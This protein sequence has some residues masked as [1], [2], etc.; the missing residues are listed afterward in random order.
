MCEKPF[1]KNYEQAKLAIKYCEKYKVNLVV[2][3]KMRYE[4]I[5][6]ELKKIIDKKTI[7]DLKF[8]SISY[9]Q[10]IP[11]QSWVIKNGI[12]REMFVH[13]LDIVM[14][15]IGSNIKV[16]YID[17]KIYSKYEQR[18]NAK[19]KY[20]KINCFINNG[21]LSDYANLNGKSDFV[22]NAIGSKG[23][24]IL[25]RP[26]FLKVFLSKK[27]ISLNFPKFDYDQPFYN[28][29]KN[30]ISYIDTEKNDQLVVNKECLNFHKIIDKVET[31]E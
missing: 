14:W 3:F 16:E 13:P 5:F 26:N 29:W 8:I 10:K 17:K 2:G 11:Y 25:I 6:M 22:L 19:L 24:I 9:F 18:I 31:Y 30:F 12:H 1:T 15:L 27:V 7:G 20:K 28:E 21:W 4:K 23:Q